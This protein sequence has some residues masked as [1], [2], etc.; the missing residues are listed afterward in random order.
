MKFRKEVAAA[1]YNAQKVA[2]QIK[3]VDQ[4]LLQQFYMTYNSARLNKT[5]VERD[6]DAKKRAE[7]RRDSIKKRVNA[8]LLEKVDLQKATMGVMYAEEEVKSSQAKLEKDLEDLSSQLSRI[9]KEDE[10]P[11]YSFDGSKL[12]SDITGSVERNFKV[13]EIKFELSSLEKTIQKINMDFIPEI[14]AQGSWATNGS[15]A[16][17]SE[18]L[19]NNNLYDSDDVKFSGAISLV[20]PLGWEVNRALKATKQIELNQK[21]Y[22]LDYLM[23]ELINVEK[24]L[25][26]RISLVR[27]NIASGVERRLISIKALDETN[28]LYN[29]GRTYLDNVL[30]SEETLTNTE[31]GIAGYIFNLEALLAQQAI[32]YGKLKENLT[33]S[34]T[35]K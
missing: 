32:L 4:I 29:R 23:N 25:K 12:P 2:A 24:G 33:S 15:G 35:V 14:Q 8:G 5:L 31:K 16:T 9:V 27:K 20:M 26:T 34:A 17:W 10:I 30:I 3:D 11:A 6:L 28:K 22:D 1:E 21:T 7:V 18:S 13:E 19:A